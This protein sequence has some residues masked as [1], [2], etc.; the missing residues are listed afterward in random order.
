MASQS[1]LAETLRQVATQQQKT[2]TEITALEGTVTNLNTE[3]DRLN[4][5][6][7]AGGPVTDELA[8]AGAE[9]K[10]LAQLADDQIPDVPAPPPT[11]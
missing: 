6:I 9:V 1:E 7:A 3:V 8:A 2:I 10:R 5:L 4:A 11:A